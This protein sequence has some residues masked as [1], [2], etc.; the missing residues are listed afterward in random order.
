[1]QHARR[2]TS[3]AERFGAASGHAV[4][5][6]ALRERRLADWFIAHG[7][8]RFFA[9]AL[10][11][12][13]RLAVL[14]AILCLLAAFAVVLLFVWLLA[15]G[16]SK[17]EIVAPPKAAEWRSGWLGFGLYDQSGWRIDPHDPN[18]LFRDG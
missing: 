3:T 8:P 7:C 9:S 14:C 13:A 4:R 5:A 10:M 2:H 16:Y 12:A 11:W 18:D 6:L 1:M 15:K 17:S